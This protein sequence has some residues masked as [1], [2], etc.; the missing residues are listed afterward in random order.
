MAA[1]CAIGWQANALIFLTG[2]K[3]IHDKDGKIIRWLEAEQINLLV[4]SSI[5]ADK[6]LPKLVACHDALKQGVH[7]VRIFPVSHI[8]SLPSFFMERLDCGTEI[9]ISPQQRYRADLAIPS[10]RKIAVR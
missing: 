4:T 6:V 2:G 10:S 8:Q 9:I 5:V 7:R 1:A 3:G